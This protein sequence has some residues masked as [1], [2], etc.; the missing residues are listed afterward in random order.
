M[1]RNHMYTRLYQAPCQLCLTTSLLA[2]D[3]ISHEGPRFFTLVQPWRTSITPRLPLHLFW[4]RDNWLRERNSSPFE[5]N[6]GKNLNMNNP[7]WLDHVKNN[8]MWTFMR[9]LVFMQRMK[10]K[11]RCLKLHRQNTVNFPISACEM[12]KK[13]KQRCRLW[14]FAW[15]VFINF[16]FCLPRQSTW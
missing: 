13:T 14:M 1:I 11:W 15:S 6:F 5:Q 16:H 4:L 10:T 8:S 3:D 2:T 12:V 9:R 7:R